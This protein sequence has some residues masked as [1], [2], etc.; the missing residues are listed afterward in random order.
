[1]NSNLQAVFQRT[2]RELDREPAR[3]HGYLLAVTMLQRL[4]VSLN[5]LRV[6][7]IEPELALK[8]RKRL[9]D[10]VALELERLGDAVG[11]GTR[12]AP[13]PQFSKAL[14]ALHGAMARTAGGASLRYIVCA[15]VEQQVLT[16]QVAAAQL[17][18]EK[19]P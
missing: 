3:F 8:E 18:D 15:H 17:G 14:H 6:I 1:M 16:L 9:G 2:M 7:G 13:S 19:V 5:T 4:L 12:P 11:K 10:D